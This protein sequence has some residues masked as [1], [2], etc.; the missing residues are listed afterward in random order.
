MHAC[1]L[2]LGSRDLPGA[3]GQSFHVGIYRWIGWTCGQSAWPGLAAPCY[4]SENKGRVGSSPWL[5]Q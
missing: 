3:G 1:S 5:L 4:V 2:C